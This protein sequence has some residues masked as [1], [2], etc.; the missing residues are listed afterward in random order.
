MGD[1]T[2][3]TNVSLEFLFF[4]YFYLHVLMDISIN[5]N[6]NFNSNLDRVAEAQAFS[7]PIGSVINRLRIHFHGSAVVML[8]DYLLS[9][10]TCL[11]K[12]VRVTWDSL[13]LYLLL[14]ISHPPSLL[15]SIGRGPDSQLDLSQLRRIDVTDS[16]Y[17]LPSS[18]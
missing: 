14:Y 1:Y 4:F 6:P 17:I 16:I 12:I 15:L 10:S 13:P 2:S 8:T 7:K 18:D 9:F 3:V 5:I 11:L